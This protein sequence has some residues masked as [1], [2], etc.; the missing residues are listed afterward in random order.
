[1]YVLGMK[2]FNIHWQVTGVLHEANN[3]LSNVIPKRRTGRAST[4]SNVQLSV[5][6]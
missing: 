6:P 5:N 2:E 1:M 3:L 4:A